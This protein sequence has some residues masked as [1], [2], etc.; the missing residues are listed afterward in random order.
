MEA[1][2]PSHRSGQ[3]CG[4][5]DC[6][7][8]RLH[9]AVLHGSCGWDRLPC[10][11]GGTWVGIYWVSLLQCLVTPK[12]MLR[13][14]GPGSYLFKGRLKEVRMLPKS[15]ILGGQFLDKLLQKVD[16]CNARSSEP[17]IEGRLPLYKTSAQ[18]LDTHGCRVAIVWLSICIHL[19]RGVGPSSW[20][21]LVPYQPEMDV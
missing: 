4:H 14:L 1:I 11:S 6:G 9:Q 3:T 5:C 7:V 15:L 21:W 16:H 18:S 12:C 19:D 13:N 10:G 17:C 8:E 2:H 20:K